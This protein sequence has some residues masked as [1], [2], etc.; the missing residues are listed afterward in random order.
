LPTIDDT[1]E[2]WNMLVLRSDAQ[3]RARE[4]NVR[5]QQG[6][7]NALLDKL[8]AAIHSLRVFKLEAPAG[9]PKLLG[10]SSPGYQDASST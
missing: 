8:E 10:A 3:E 7:C 6:A 1:I 4:Q 2:Y 5:E 9:E